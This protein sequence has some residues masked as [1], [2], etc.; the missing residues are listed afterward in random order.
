MSYYTA[1]HI[2]FML[3]IKHKLGYILVQKSFQPLIVF[4]RGLHTQKRKENYFIILH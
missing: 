1:I 2:T 3:Y 4:F